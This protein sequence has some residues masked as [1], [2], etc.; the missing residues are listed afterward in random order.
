MA[1]AV[2]KQV[3][4]IPSFWQTLDYTKLFELRVLIFKYANECWERVEMWGFQVDLT[5]E[6]YFYGIISS[7]FSK[8]KWLGN[9]VL[10]ALEVP[11]QP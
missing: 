2:G 5:T 3:S 6:H 4:G 1:A 11:L 10:N 8:G 9:A 7:L